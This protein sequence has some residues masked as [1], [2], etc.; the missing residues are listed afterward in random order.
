L[1]ALKMRIKADK[2]LGSVDV[3][4]TMQFKGSI[5]ASSKGL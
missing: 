2:R 5:G 1:C 3:E 4:Y